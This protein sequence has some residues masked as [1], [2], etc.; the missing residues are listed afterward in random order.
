MRGRVL[1]VDDHR[2]I[3]YA[4]RRLLESRGLE[5][6]SAHT[7]EEARPRFAEADAAILDIQLEADSGL[8]LL[9]ELRNA[10]DET[11]AIVLSAHTF[12]DN[13]VQAS[14]H[15]ALNV[16]SKPLDSSE[17]L[18]A[19]EEALSQ[20]AA[21][22]AG[23][24]PSLADEAYGVLGSS[25][26]MMEVFKALGVAAGNELN[27]LITG[28]TGVGKE[29][30]AE[31]IH[32]HSGRADGPFVAINCTAV[33]ESLLEAE[34][35]GYAAGAFT[36]ANRAS[37]GKVEAAAGGTLFLDEIGDMPLAFQAKLLRFLEDKSFYRLGESQPRRADVRVV[38]ATNQQLTGDDEHFRS[39]LYFRLAHIPVQIPALRER[40][41]DIPALVEAFIA[42]ANREMG[43]DIQGVSATAQE[44]AQAHPWPGN[45]RELKNTIL[46][47]AA[48]QQRG[49]IERLEL[50]PAPAGR[51][52]TS[53][54]GDPLDS[55]IDHA[56]ATGELQDLMNEFE[57][58]ALERSLRYYHGN[59]SRVA[60][61]L[62]VS[63]N[64]LRAKLRAQ[65]MAEAAAQDEGSTA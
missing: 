53:G 34:L 45:V 21:T 22:A 36:G 55:R 31:I 17:L 5:V 12:P 52:A 51:E 27:V 38:A 35:F 48:K 40:P 33:P 54:G 10:G 4:V 57:R 32:R 25:P 9:E 63:R 58:R 65:G 39:D 64:T 14:K 37:V 46:R 47:A 24:E 41:E 15:G 30:A 42:T 62:G 61:A 29:V 28:E 7:P 44:Q 43:L 2:E 3:I 1:V 13:V 49:I 18:A 26:A 50:T 8:A 11:P 56:L 20:S 23:G 19:V 59:K 6:L 16:L 60:A